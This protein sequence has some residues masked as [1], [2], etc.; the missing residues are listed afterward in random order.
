PAYQDYL[1]RAQMAEAIILASGQKVAV[2]EQFAN[3][4]TCAVNGS[5]GIAAA[6]DIRGKYVAKVDVGGTAVAGGGCTSIA[7]LN[8]ADTFA[9]IQG[10]T[11]TLTLSNADTGAQ[12]WACTSDAPQK[13]LPKACTGT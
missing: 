1:A 12:M 5:G 6:T 8:A 11:L 2:A 7:T 10:K 13:Y 9:G 3:D 4:G